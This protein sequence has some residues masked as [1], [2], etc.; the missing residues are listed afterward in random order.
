MRNGDI[1][2]SQKA[3]SD[4]LESLVYST[5]PPELNSLAWLLLVDQTISDPALPPSPH[6]REYGLKAVLVGLITR[7]L[8]EGRRAFG[9]EPPDER[10]PLVEVR[11]QIA[12][13]AA[14][15]SADLLSSSLLYHRFVRVDL[16]LSLE[17][18][19]QI[20]GA[21]ARTLRR[22]Q[23]YGI[24]GLTHRLIE[25]ERDAR[26]EGRRR[27][28]YAALPI[29]VPQPLYGRDVWLNEAEA[30]LNVTQPR[31]L[32]VTGAVGMGKTAFVMALLRRQIDADLL[33]QIVWIDAPKSVDD[34]RG[35]V[36]ERI[37]REG[38]SGLRETLLVYR[39]A[40]VLDELD[41][42]LADLDALLKLLADLSAA[43]VYLINTTVV[44]LPAL[45]L[46]LPEL[47][48]V[49]TAA[50]VRAS[51]PVGL[52]EG[53]EFVG[54]LAAAA[55]ETVGGNPEAIIL[56]AQRLEFAEWETARAAAQARVFEQ[57]LAR[58]DGK[59]LTFACA[60]ALCPRGA[61]ALEDAIALWPDYVSADGAEGLLANHLAE[62]I[63]GRYWLAAGL[64]D[65]LRTH[66]AGEVRTMLELLS[67]DPTHIT[68]GALTLFEHLL[69]TDAIPL[70]SARREAWIMQLCR[71]GLARGRYARWRTLLESVSPDVLDLRIAYGGCLRRLGEW[72]AAET[73]LRDAAA[74]SGSRGLFAEQTRALLEWSIAAR[75]RG[76]YR[77]AAALLAQVERTLK[78][79]PD[80]AMQEMLQLELAQMALDEGRGAD[81]LRMLSGLEVTPR[82]LAM[83]S[84]AYL[85]LGDWT[86]CRK[87][88]E[89][90][91]GML[92]SR[93]GLLARLYT[94]LGRGY[95]G[96]QDI[97]S[98]YH[99]M[100]VAVT[101][102]EQLEDIHALARAQ[103]NLAA[104]CLPLGYYDDAGR[105]LA[106]AARL[107]RDLGDQVGLAATRH[108]QRLLDE[109]L[110]R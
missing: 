78:R 95:Q 57:A 16:G 91:I 24:R 14:T 79:R 41:A 106:N 75:Y 62:R 67:P 71:V 93:T 2:V 104:L 76:D 18:I 85:L 58:L 102:L 107:Q 49:A 105:L 26:R 9:L 36:A 39:T 3:V 66:R 30:R 5:R 45:H 27:R 83:Q 100:S 59:A 70:D 25:A 17:D 56:L 21:D 103:S 108:N 20:I 86:A 7:A 94:A 10:A 89:R 43:D 47:D 38:G 44:N 98:A 74:T 23:S 33:D 64:L 81:A 37:L 50:L 92:N 65:Y 8:Q 19:S 90:G 109:H 6:A 53:E 87:A 88:A 28:L 110:A 55:Q 29:P 46:P 11:R 80:L 13:D 48:I 31:H 96:I 72:L 60:L 63:H 22:Y 51:L 61:A 12:A 52:R 69:L 73:V 4:A 34:V 40:I 68:D 32:L 101:V 35:Q 15:H 99:C 77:T 1:H 97:D 84:E 54:E 42:L 82:V